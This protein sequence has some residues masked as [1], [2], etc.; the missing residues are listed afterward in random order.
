MI[1]FEPTEEQQM[2][3]DTAAAFARN[4]LRPAARAVDEGETIPDGLIAAASKLGLVRAWLPEE[5]GG[6]GLMRSALTGAMLMEELAYG[7]LALAAHLTAPRLFAF[8]IIEM[9]TSAQRSRYL[10]PFASGNFVAGSSALVEPRYDFD[11]QTIATTARQERDGWILDGEKCIVPLAGES[12]SILIYARRGEEDGVS[13]FIV[14]REAAGVLISEPE[15]NMGLKGLKTYEVKLAGCRIA[16]DAQLG[17][18]AGINFARIASQMR[19]AAVA[20]AAGL[21]RAAFEYARDYAK[22]RRAFGAPIATRQAIA[23]MLAEMAIEV[24]AMRLLAWEAAWHLDRGEDAAKES[25]L[26]KH[27]ASAS[28]LKV[29]DNAV[30]VLGGHGYIREHP[31]EMWLRNAR[32]LAI[33]EGL[34]IV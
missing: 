19:V 5:H 15:K 22:E 11:L 32:G 29:T 33:M 3:R 12:E 8:P 21:A 6:D 30:Q 26:A 9:G 10:K 20:M 34:A 25:Y 27:Y 14:P 23:F 28:A 24:D 16:A 4:E 1:S 2:I 7:D 13:G 18:D 31:V 17:G